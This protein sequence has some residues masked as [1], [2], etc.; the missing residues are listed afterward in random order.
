MNKIIFA[1]SC[2]LLLLLF[3]FAIY[4][5]SSMKFR[6]DLNGNLWSSFFAAILFTIFLFLVN[7]L[8]FK[9]NVNG[10]WNVEEVI[11][12]PGYTTYINYK[13]QYVFHL[14]QIGAEVH[15][16]G[17]KI[18]QI[19]SPS[20]YFIKFERSKRVRLEISGFIDK[21]YF[22]KTKVTMLIYEKGRERD[23][24]SYVYLTYNKGSLTGRFSSTAGDAKG[25]I[26]MNLISNLT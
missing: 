11:E 14:I 23:T 2:L 17:E 13:L 9:V 5:F 18:S 7:E 1:F 6:P 4:D 26:S 25:S 19:E 24:S 12:G 20:G 21:T 16:F 22:G 15:G 8:F 3:S 10:E